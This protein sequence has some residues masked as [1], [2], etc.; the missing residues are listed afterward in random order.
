MKVA[1]ALI[2][3]SDKNGLG[4]FAEG[5]HELG[6]ELIST[7]GTAAFLEE[8][9]LPVT[10]VEDLTGQAELLEG[11]VKTLHPVVFAGILARRDRADDM[12]SLRAQG[13]EPIDMV[14]SNLYPFRRVS[15]R[16]GVPEAEI[17][18]N[19]DVGGP[20]MVRAAAKNHAS[21]AV[22]TAPE[23]Y[24]F[25]L[26]EL[27]SS[28]GALSDDTRRELAADAFSHTASYDAA[29]A[30]WFTDTEP[31]P[32]RLV[33]DYLKVT[34]LTYGENPHQRAAFYRDA[35]ARRHLLSRVE[36]HGGPQL[37]FNNLGDLHAARILAAAFQVP[38]A[39][40][41]KHGI[42]SG[43]A[44]GA[45]L[46]EAFE[47]ALATDKE[48][49]FGAVIAVNRP[50]TAELATS[51]TER[52][53]DV[54]FAPGYE[55]GAVDVLAKKPSIRILEDQERRKTSPGERDIRRVIG[56]VLVQDRDM[57][58]DERETMEV[59]TETHPSKRQW[60]DLLFA[61][62]IAH[63]VRSNAIV[64]AKDLATVGI[65]AGQV[66]RVD[67]VRLAVEKAGDRA[68]GSVMASDAF[69][70]FDDGPKAAFAAG[71]TAVIQPG[72]SVRDDEIIA[73]CNEAG[74]AMVFT[75]RRHFVH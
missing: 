57:E 29:I 46:D 58:L 45:S 41:I 60:D 2:S 16:R 73:A 26:D 32:D 65:G 59:V 1:R 74:V 38:A 15:G 30:G 56:G 3:V 25:I 13:I 5:L 53:L 44:V 70:P 31:F 10:R 20:S 17:L 33:L 11:R 71:V 19:I 12:A 39:V 23:R 14:V 72:G 37:S 27:T 42:P 52:K 67:A 68:S 28:G 22:V 24:G 21:V 50:I 66:S 4:T 51:M 55:D 36:Q 6:I 35:G 75:G 47:L 64:L 40:I 69:F 9:G 34:D 43:V 8:A 49:A 18:E 48:A 54:L 62:R 7:S 61:W 63:F